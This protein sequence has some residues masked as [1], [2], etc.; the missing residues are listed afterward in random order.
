M[1]LADVNGDGKPDLLVA[2]LCGDSTSTCAGTVAVLFGNG[3]GTFQ[4]A[5][6]YG[7]G[8]ESAYLVAVADVN[9]DGKPDLLVAN[10]FASNS[11]T[12]GTVGVLLGKGDG[13][14]QPAVAY[15]SGGVGAQ[16]VAVADVNGDGKPDLLVTNQCVNSS[17][18]AYSTVGVLLGNGDGTFQPAVAYG[19]GGADAPSVAVGDVNGDGKPDLLVANACAI[20]NCTNGTV[21]VLLGNGD[22]TFQAAVTYGSGG[23][24]ASSVAMADVNHDGK[25]DLL[26]SNLCASNRSA[27]RQRR[28]NLPGDDCLLLGC[29]W[30]LFGGSG[31]CEWGWQA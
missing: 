31:R 30:Q 24:Q 13:T 27:P 21:D 26:V 12:N 25:P 5:A 22:G 23:S 4:P 19:S 3:D 6:S 7:S 11:N 1:A 20:S 14:F 17:N 18:C 2:N 28:W 29:V 10:A 15:G 9:G 8:G 16:S